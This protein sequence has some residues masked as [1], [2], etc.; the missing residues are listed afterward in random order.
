MSRL[1]RVAD[2][3]SRQCSIVLV[4][5]AKISRHVKEITRTVVLKVSEANDCATG[6]RAKA[7]DSCQLMSVR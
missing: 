7:S 5:H 2:D 3:M 1:T 4:L 6:L